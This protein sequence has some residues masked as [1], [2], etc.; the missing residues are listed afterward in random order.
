M[1][2][3]TSFE[4]RAKERL[5][6]SAPPGIFYN[7]EDPEERRWVGN[8]RNMAAF[9]CLTLRARVM[10]DVSERQLTSIVLG[11]EI[12]FPILLAPAGYLNRFHPDGELAI[13]RAASRAGTIMALSTASSF[14]LEDVASSTSTPMWFQLYPMSDRKLNEHLVKR[15][16]EAGFSALVVTVDNPNIR[17]YEWDDSPIV[18]SGGRFGSFDESLY[19]RVPLSREE[20]A[21][22]RATDFQWGDVADLVS[23]TKLPVVLKGVQTPE[24]AILAEHYGVRG[25]VVSNHGGYN[26]PTAAATIRILPEIADVA[27]GMEVYLDG[28]VR[29]GSDVL[30]AV[31]LG[32][33]AVFVGRPMVWSLVVDGEAGVVMMLEALRDEL[34]AAMG[35]CGV[36]DIRQVTRRYVCTGEAQNG[37]GVDGLRR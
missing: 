4:L 18:G 2:A 22:F 27:G 13:A 33:K 32:A 29:S 9:R 20:F 3:V 36:A 24:D 23:I 12:A 7:E 25:I 16:E 15:A 31:A 30:K 17:P 21:A 28:G 8:S 14:S 10:R 26:L 34:G 11:Q 1:Q 37:R 6:R 19:A 5:G 35:L